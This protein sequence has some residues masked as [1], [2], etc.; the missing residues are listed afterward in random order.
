MT[1]DYFLKKIQDLRCRY[2]DKEAEYFSKNPRCESCTEERLA[3]LTIHHVHGKKSSEVQVL[4]FNC[5]MVFHSKAKWTHQDHLL[6][7]NKKEQ[8]K[9]NK[10]ERNLKMIKAYQEKKSLRKVGEMFGV[11]Y[12]TVRNVL[13]YTEG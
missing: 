6:Y 8:K 3:A 13:K 1:K 2:G 11:S 4:C 7:K 10:H 12:V 9:K 5:H